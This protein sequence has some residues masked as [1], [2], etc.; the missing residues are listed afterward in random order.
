MSHRY[1]FRLKP[2]RDQDLITWLDSL[3]EGE[4]SFFI[5]NTLR[6]AITGNGQVVEFIN[7]PQMDF[8]KVST[9]SVQTVNSAYMENENGVDK[10]SVEHRF[11]KLMDSF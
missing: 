5:R 10:T 9:E 6:K 11:E 2:G 4:R 3:G 7:K 1:T 8:K